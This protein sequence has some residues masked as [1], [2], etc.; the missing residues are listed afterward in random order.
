MDYFSEEIISYKGLLQ[1][2]LFK[3]NNKGDSPFLSYEN[4]AVL[5]TADCDL[6]NPSKNVN[7]YTFLP[8]ISSNSYIDEIWISEYLEKKLIKNSN[9]LSEYISKNK[10]HELNDCN[11]ISGI[12]LYS[13]VKESGINDIVISLGLNKEDQKIKNTIKILE[14]INSDKK[15]MS[16]LK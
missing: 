11:P 14:L 6:A 1:G 5:I 15:M 10:I 2:D 9:E 12:D 8:I 7:Y 4:Y 13:W 16:T 3:V